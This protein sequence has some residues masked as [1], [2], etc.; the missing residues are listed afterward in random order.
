M[1]HNPLLYHLFYLF[2]LPLHSC[3]FNIAYI[4]DSSPDLDLAIC[5]IFF[6]FLL[7]IDLRI[8]RKFSFWLPIP[9][10]CLVYLLFICVH[11]SNMYS[12]MPLLFATLFF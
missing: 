4:L 11:L 3:K 9:Y 6:S 8:P 1:I 10:R 7:I 12:T 2:S 5:L